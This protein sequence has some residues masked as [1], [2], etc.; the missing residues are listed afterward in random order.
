MNSKSLDRLKD[1]QEYGISFNIAGEY[2]YVNVSLPQEWDVRVI[3]EYK[4]KGNSVNVHAYRGEDGVYT[5]YT[6][7][8]NDITYLFTALDDC[9]KINTEYNKRVILFNELVEKLAIFVQDKSIDEVSRIEFIVPKE[10]RKYSKK[11]KVSEET[12]TVE[13]VEPKKEEVND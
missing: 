1:Y 5:F 3:Y 13:E 9:I 12:E 7:L 8:A 4:S 11:S 2:S 10:K 6:N